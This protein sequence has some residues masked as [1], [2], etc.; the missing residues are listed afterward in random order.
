M[1]Q[2]GGWPGGA[3]PSTSFTRVDRDPWPAQDRD[4][5][6]HRNT[7]P[8]ELWAPY[9]GLRTDQRCWLGGASGVAPH[10]TTSVSLLRAAFE[11]GKLGDSTTWSGVPNQQEIYLLS[12]SSEAYEYV[13]ARVDVPAPP[14]QPPTPPPVPPEPDPPQ[15]PAPPAEPAIVE[16]V[17]ALEGRADSA[18]RDLDLLERRIDATRDEAGELRRDHE[19]FVA[20]ARRRVEALEQTRGQHADRLDGAAL[21]RADL[22]ARLAALEGQNQPAP[23]PPGPQPQPPGPPQGGGR[24]LGELSLPGRYHVNTAAEPTGAWDVPIAGSPERVGRV[25]VSFSCLLPAGLDG[26]R[27]EIFA[28]VFNGR[29]QMGIPGYLFCEGNGRGTFRAGD[30]WNPAVG[31]FSKTPV[32]LDGQ[33]LEVRL[34]CDW[35]RGRNALQVNER[36]V[37]GFVPQPETVK[38]FLRVGFGI[39]P[40]FANANPQEAPSIGFEYSDLL[41]RIYGEVS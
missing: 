25:A 28:A 11:A 31:P 30:A 18:S 36:T 5:Q 20:I 3:C 22:A 37:T 21:A 34:V 17:R 14:P 10:D 12:V 27:R 26:R 23:Q 9:L 40:E 38:R 24:L 33:R 32:T 7:I 16:R 1:A 15:P 8:H 4:H 13:R 19:G 6:Q 39:P 2:S 35:G 41:V 29:G